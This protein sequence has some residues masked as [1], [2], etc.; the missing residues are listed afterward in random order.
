VTLAAA[1]NVNGDAPHVILIGAFADA[2][3]VENL[4]KKLRE[5][6]IPVYTEA[7]DSPQGVRKTRVRA[8]PFRN[9]AAAEAALAKMRRTGVKDCQD[10]KIAPQP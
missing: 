7:L 10:C 2:A 9:R 3:N 6:N 1:A 4:K 5:L 8:G